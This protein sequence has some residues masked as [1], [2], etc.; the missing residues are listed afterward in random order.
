MFDIIIAYLIIGFLWL[1][2][3]DV[4]IQKMPNNGT[5]IRYLFLWPFTLI[6]FLIGIF[7]AWNN[8]NNEN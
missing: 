2:I 6:A 3:W 4:F 1:T 8:R 7:Q 5:R